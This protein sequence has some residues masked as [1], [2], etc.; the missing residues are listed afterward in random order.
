MEPRSPGAQSYPPLGWLTLGASFTFC[1][2][3]TL[4][5]LEPGTSHW[6]KPAL[7]ARGLAGP[8]LSCPQQFS[9]DGRGNVQLCSPSSSHVPKYTFTQELER[10]LLGK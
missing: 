10:A 2:D 7:R 1:L 5:F 9:L 6:E 3:L 8:G 4:S